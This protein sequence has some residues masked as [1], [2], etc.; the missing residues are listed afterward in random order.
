MRTIRGRNTIYHED[1]LHLIQNTHVVF[2]DRPMLLTTHSGV[3]IMCEIEEDTWP[4]VLNP[5]IGR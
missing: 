5:E 3:V 1:N 4:A 2:N